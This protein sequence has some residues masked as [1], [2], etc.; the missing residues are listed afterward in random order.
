MRNGFLDAILQRLASRLA[1]WRLP[2]N[3]AI[4]TGKWSEAS[5]VKV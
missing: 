4:S 3:D 2:A 5:Q 1:K